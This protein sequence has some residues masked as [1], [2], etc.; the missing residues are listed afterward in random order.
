MWNSLPG[1]KRAVY[2]LLVLADYVK[3]TFSWN[4]NVRSTLNPV[5]TINNVEATFDFVAVFSNNVER[6]FI[7]PSSLRQS[8][9]KL[10]M[11]NLFRLRRINS[12][13]VAFDNV[14]VYMGL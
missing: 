5:H 3:R 14:A 1:F 13:L 12:R 2:T 11:I 9:N 7:K 10:N 4:N 6:V 8:R